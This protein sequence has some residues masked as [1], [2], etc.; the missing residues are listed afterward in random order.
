MTGQSGPT[1]G[2]P[3]SSSSATSTWT[4]D[5]LYEAFVSTGL[6]PPA[7]LNTVPRT[8]F[9][10]DK[11]RHFYDQLA[12]FSKPDGTSLLRGLAYGQQAGS[13]DFIPHVH[14][15]LTRNEVSWRISDHYP[16]WC[17]FLLG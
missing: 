16:P 7:E 12:W 4:G 9:D 10:D 15:G 17:E 11:T 1:T 8:I 2:T 14:R 3:T 6:W 5:P 13:S